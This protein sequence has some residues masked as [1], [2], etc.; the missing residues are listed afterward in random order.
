MKGHTFNTYLITGL[1]KI[2]AFPNNPF[3]SYFY[4]FSKDVIESNCIVIIGTSLSD[5]HIKS[6]LRNYLANPDSKVIFVTD[7]TSDKIR[8]I[9]LGNEFMMKLMSFF[10]YDTL[11]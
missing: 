2:E 5:D 7:T 6:I 11:L 8:T 3:S 10:N 4:R 1:D 9:H